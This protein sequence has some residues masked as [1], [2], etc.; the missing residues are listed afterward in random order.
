MTVH[1]SSYFSID[2]ENDIVTLHDSTSFQN[3]VS[4][5]INTHLINIYGHENSRKYVT[6]D[7]AITIPSYIKNIIDSTENDE[8]NRFSESIAKRLL[9]SEKDAQD[10]IGHLNQEVQKGGLILTYFTEG[11]KSYFALAK[12]H[13]I[14]G[15]TENEFEKV[16]VT[17][18]KEHMLKTAIVEIINTDV[19]SIFELID[20]TKNKGE[21]AAKYWWSDFLELTAL[22]SNQENSKNAVARID[23]FLKDKF[24][25][26]YREDYW[27]C[28][29][30][31]V[32]Y[33]NSN[34]TF[35]MQDMVDSVFGDFSLDIFE[36]K[37]QS[38]KNSLKSDL[39]SG[40]SNVNTTNTG[41]VL[42]DG[43]FTIDKK[44]IKLRIKKK[45]L[46]HPSI[47]L[48]IDGEVPNIDS[49]IKTDM[50]GSRKVLKIYSNEGYDAF[51]N[52]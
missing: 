47:S 33:L 2:L 50:E 34:E 27:H 21:K 38:E 28:R 51:S 11:T 44:V 14:D 41:K 45:V 31:M 42:F 39:Q 9:R 13:F 29:N 7:S 35:V 1:Y 43:S 26:E 17:P 49:L 12:V 6:D 22:T 5:Y 8:K 23:K 48:N 36:G 18:D 32:S 24:H 52:R 19:D 10:R 3:N 25:E 30:N 16:K 15:R 37:N 20:S 40:L 4:E 46:L